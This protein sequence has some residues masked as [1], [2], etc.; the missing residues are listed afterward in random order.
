MRKVKV[1]VRTALLATDPNWYRHLEVSLFIDQSYNKGVPVKGKFE[2]YLQRHRRTVEPHQI[3][4]LG[5]W[6]PLWQGT[7]LCSYGVLNQGQL[8]HLK[9]DLYVADREERP[10]PAA[11]LL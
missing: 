5:H 6:Q 10:L 3:A 2:V 8:T 7:E 11:S 4:G 1:P 9:L